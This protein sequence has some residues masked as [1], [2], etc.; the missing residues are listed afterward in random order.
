MMDQRGGQGNIQ[1]DGSGGKENNENEDIV[2]REGISENDAMKKG[3]G[4]KKWVEKL[5]EKL[6]GFG[7]K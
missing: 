5:K 7:K 6:K 3:D 2:T 1:Y 4:Y